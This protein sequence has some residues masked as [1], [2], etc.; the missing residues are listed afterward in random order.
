MEVK[1]SYWVGHRKG[2]S[3]KAVGRDLGSERSVGLRDRCV[4]KSKIL[5]LQ[6]EELIEETLGSRGIASS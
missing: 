5:R 3:V 4:G 6:G 1:F 2:D